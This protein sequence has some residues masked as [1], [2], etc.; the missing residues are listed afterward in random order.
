MNNN[1]INFRHTL[2]ASKKQF[3]ET[4][5]KR[6]AC[7]TKVLT[8]ENIQD[9]PMNIR[10][11]RKITKTIKYLKSLRLNVSFLM[12]ISR[13][14]HKIL[15]PAKSVS[16]VQIWTDYDDRSLPHYPNNFYKSQKFQLTLRLNYNDYPN[17]LSFL[18]KVSKTR[19]C[20]PLTIDFAEITIYKFPASYLKTLKKVQSLRIDTHHSCY[21][22]VPAYV[23]SLT[24]I[25]Q[26]MKQLKVFRAKI[27][28]DQLP[29]FNDFLAFWLFM[30]QVKKIIQNSP[31][32]HCLKE[33][34]IYY[35]KVGTKKIDARLNKTVLNFYRDRQA[36]QKE[37]KTLMLWFTRLIGILVF[38][39]WKTLTPYI[40]EYDYYF[41]VNGVEISL[42]LSLFSFIVFVFLPLL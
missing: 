3:L 29:N 37:I 7:F 10:K 4:R 28:V 41:S 35:D 2:L 5:K 31:Y 42:Y 34:T 40:H 21:N 23:K 16:D 6:N 25:C 15:S 12:F 13:I 17:L 1:K 18:H 38:V 36:Y 11:A 30:H 20:E 22:Q 14:K 19:Q 8:L 39:Y 24:A 26:Q 33:F 9:L 27:Q 32:S